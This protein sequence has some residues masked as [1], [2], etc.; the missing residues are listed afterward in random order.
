MKRIAN[1]CGA[2]VITTFADDNGDEKFDSSSL[3]QA[4]EVYEERLGDNDYIFITKCKN[5]SAQCIFLRGSNDYMLDEI[6]RNIHDALK[7]L[8]NVLESN[9]V[10]AGGG[11]VESALSIYLDDFA[12]SLVL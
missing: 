11:S 9:S 5:Q 6:E 2:T 10:V 4:Q 1:A 12:R 8:K 3:G 7:S